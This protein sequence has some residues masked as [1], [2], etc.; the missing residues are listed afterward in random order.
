MCLLT[1]HR[2]C[3][4]VL[5]CCDGKGAAHTWHPCSGGTRHPYTLTL[6]QMLAAAC[7]ACPSWC[8]LWH[9]APCPTPQCHG[10]FLPS[11]LPLGHCPA[12]PSQFSPVPNLSATAFGD[13]AREEQPQCCHGHAS[14]VTCCGRFLLGSKAKLLFS[15]TS[16]RVVQ[17][18][19]FFSF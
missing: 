2:P 4:L 13:K 19:V 6:P 5:S 18:D 15:H 1:S 9:G 8:S 14:F 17:D 7:G 11:V 10:G 16:S 3:L 12:P